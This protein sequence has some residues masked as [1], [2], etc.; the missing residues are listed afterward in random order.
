MTEMNKGAPGR[1]FA[2]YRVEIDRIS[3]LVSATK[4][5]IVTLSAYF[6]FLAESSHDTF[7]EISVSAAAMFDNNSVEKRILCATAVFNIC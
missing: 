5:Y 1:V 4:V 2:W 7:G 3:V 6:R